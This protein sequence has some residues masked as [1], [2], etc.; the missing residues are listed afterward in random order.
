MFFSNLPYI[1]HGTSKSPKLT[2]CV[3]F[4]QKK[5]IV[6]AISIAKQKKTGAEAP[7]GLVGIYG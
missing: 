1:K 2:I 4:F 5:R 6:G 7:A 3:S